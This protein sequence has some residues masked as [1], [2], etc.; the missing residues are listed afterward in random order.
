M[1]GGKANFFAQATLDLWLGATVP[2]PPATVYA[3]LMTT[4][5]TDIGGGV[6]AAGGGYARVPISNDVTNFPAST[7]IGGVV[8]KTNGTGIVFPTATGSWGTT[9]GIA[10]YDAATGG[11]LMYWGPFATPVPVGSGNTVQVPIGAGVFTEG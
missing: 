11:N 2:A 7:V 10:I 9:L 1:D 8:T 6:E 3:A 4:L 5:P